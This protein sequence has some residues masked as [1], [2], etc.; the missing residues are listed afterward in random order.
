MIN[1]ISACKESAASHAQKVQ[2]L[3]MT[4]YNKLIFLKS[5]SLVENY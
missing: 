5:S 1:G 2:I 3:D 4:L